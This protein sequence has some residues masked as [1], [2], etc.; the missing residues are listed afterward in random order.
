MSAEYDAHVQTILDGLFRPEFDRNLTDQERTIMFEALDRLL[1]TARQTT[2]RGVLY[3]TAEVREVP[4]F[5]RLIRTKSTG[6]RA[7]TIHLLYDEP[8]K[9]AS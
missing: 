9:K 5:E 8:P 3:H 4:T 2:T 7:V 1:A 6:R